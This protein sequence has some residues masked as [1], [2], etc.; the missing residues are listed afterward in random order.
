M[1]FVL[2]L[3][4]C[5]DFRICERHSQAHSCN[6]LCV[7]WI[8]FVR[9]YSIF[10]WSSFCFKISLKKSIIK[11]DN[12][13]KANSRFPVVSPVWSQREGKAFSACEVSQTSQVAVAS[14]KIARRLCV[15][16]D[17]C[18]LLS[19]GIV[20]QAQRLTQYFM[21]WISATSHLSSYLKFSQ[22]LK[23]G[24]YSWKKDACFYAYCKLFALDF[25]NDWENSSP[26]SSKYFDIP[27]QPIISCSWFILH[28]SV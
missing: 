11:S 2:I 12:R 22:S 16:T 21:T 14:R 15:Y 19:S 10:I 8:E 20:I 7:R 13:P 1:A 4:D 6:N 25:G 24:V 18:R 27:S 17:A 26:Y 5:R 9:E 23:W 3:Q 28:I